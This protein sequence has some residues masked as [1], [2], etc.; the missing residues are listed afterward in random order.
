MSTQQLREEVMALPLKERLAL[1]D[2]I[3]ESAEGTDLTFD[4]E[5]AAELQRRSAEMRDGTVPIYT[6]EEVMRSARQATGC[7]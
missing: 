5:W 6:H 7:N 2:E 1:A 3:Y 4:P